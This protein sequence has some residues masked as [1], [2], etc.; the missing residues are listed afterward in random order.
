V[1]EGIAEKFAP[2]PVTF[3]I[4][5]P[6]ARE[7]EM[8]VEILYALDCPSHPA[9][10]ALVR[11]VLAAERITADVVEVLVADD[12]M[13]RKLRFPGSPTIRIDGLDVSPQPESPE[14][15]GLSCRLYPGLGQSGLPPRELVRRAV[16]ASHFG[17]TA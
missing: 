12:A 17:E 1:R 14:T 9:A 10:V 8:R 3:R 13:A 15:F 6:P 4:G 16:R 5:Q 7:G 2:L 11:D